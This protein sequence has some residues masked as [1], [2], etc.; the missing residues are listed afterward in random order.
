MILD[1][2]TNAN[3][4]VL[5]EAIRFVTEHEVVNINLS[6]KIKTVTPQ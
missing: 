1:L 5:D 3:A 6:R 4:T 2:F